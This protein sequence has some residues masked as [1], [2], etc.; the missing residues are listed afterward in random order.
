[1][2]DLLEQMRDLI[3][4]KHYSLRAEVAY[5]RWIMECLRLRVKDIDFGYGQIIVRDGKGQSV[6]CRDEAETGRR[7]PGVWKQPATALQGYLL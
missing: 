6:S 5:L 7:Q 1:M 2:P 3:R 4:L